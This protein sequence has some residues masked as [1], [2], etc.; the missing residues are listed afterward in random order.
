MYDEWQPTRGSSGAGRTVLITRSTGSID[1]AGV[2]ATRRRNGRRGWS[3][4]RLSEEPGL[5]LGL[6][7]T[8]SQ[9]L[10]WVDAVYGSATYMPMV[11]GAAYVSPSA[12][13]ACS[14]AERNEVARRAVRQWP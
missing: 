1:L 3:V 14:R 2:T 5:T 9:W 13:L 8:Y 11:G 10:R 4:H 6:T 7:R 12:Q